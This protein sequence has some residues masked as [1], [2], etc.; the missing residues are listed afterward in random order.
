MSQTQKDSHSQQETAVN[1]VTGWRTLALMP[2]SLGIHL[3]TRTLR[4]EMSPSDEARF[5]NTPS[6]SL[7]L[8]W[9]HG[10]FVAAEAKRRYRRKQPMS[11]LISA[12]KDGAW[13][14]ALYKL[15]GIG[16]VRGSSSFRGAQALQECLATMKAGSDIVITPDG[17]RGPSCQVKRGPAF[18]AQKSDA[19][20]VLLSTHFAKAKRF[21]SWDG[22]YLPY[23]F[24]TVR[25][26]CASYA[27]I[28]ALMET[29][30]EAK[31]EANALQLGL[32]NL[33]QA[34]EFSEHKKAFRP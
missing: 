11:G 8:F 31:S 33:Y 4:M 12:S 5:S 29:F 15:L 3:W 2:L 25:I 20:I 17:P 27:N 18:L 7:F 32:E 22:F 21:N 23:P 26:G 10:L 1:N 30:P 9:H 24:S 6:P 14:A 19:S 13:L 28:D 16:F 34:N